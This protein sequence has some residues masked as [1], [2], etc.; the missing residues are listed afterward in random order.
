MRTSLQLA[1]IDFNWRT[2]L[3][4]HFVAPDFNYMWHACHISAAPPA[5]KHDLNQGDIV[6]LSRRDPVAENGGMRA[7]A[8]GGTLPDHLV[9][10]QRLACHY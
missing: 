8:A 4:L 10:T 6:L 2:S 3:Q 5:P 9:V 1:H 7:A